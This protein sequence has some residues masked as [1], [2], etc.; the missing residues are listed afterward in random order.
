MQKRDRPHVTGSVRLDKVLINMPTVP[1]LAEGET[2]VGL[3]VKLELG[4]EIH[5]YNKYLY[6]LLGRRIA[7]HRQYAYTM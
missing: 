5:L 6:D 4:P 7:H 1:E 2:N 3:D